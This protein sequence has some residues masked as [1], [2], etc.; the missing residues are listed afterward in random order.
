MMMYTD[1]SVCSS[2]RRCLLCL[3]CNS[4]STDAVNDNDELPSL[5][6]STLY[7]VRRFDPKA[8]C[9]LAHS[10]IFPPVALGL[11]LN[12]GGKRGSRDASIGGVAFLFEAVLH[13]TFLI[14]Q[15]FSDHCEDC[16]IT[17]PSFELM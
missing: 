16:V 7:G 8:D 11:I 4:S 10:K 1:L 12:V 13:D 2:S 6:P 5:L 15:R 14:Y 3:Y 9:R 17:L